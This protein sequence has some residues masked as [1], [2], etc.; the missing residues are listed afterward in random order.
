MCAYV[1]PN[2]QVSVVFKMCKQT[3]Q[4]ARLFLLRLTLV[5][6][7]DNVTF[8]FSATIISFFLTA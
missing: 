2:G 8:T 4:N 7:N 5:Y 1:I 3:K 6:F